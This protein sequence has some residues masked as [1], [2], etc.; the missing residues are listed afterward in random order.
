MKPKWNYKVGDEIIDK[1]KEE[2][3]GG[4]GTRQPITRKTYKYNSSFIE[5]TNEQE[6]II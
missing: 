3:L 1:G 5:A 6:S 4:D 2:L